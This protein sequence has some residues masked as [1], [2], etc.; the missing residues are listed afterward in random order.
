MFLTLFVETN[1]L[2]EPKFWFTPFYLMVSVSFEFSNNLDLLQEL[3]GYRDDIIRE[4][5]RVRNNVN[6]TRNHNEFV[7]LFSSYHLKNNTL[8]ATCSMHVQFS[9]HYTIIYQKKKPCHMYIGCAF[10]QILWC[11]ML[12]ITAQVHGDFQKN[13]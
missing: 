10:P 7:N 2:K 13:V 8:T 3:H 4:T 1:K 6:K 5:D 12:N 11:M 9:V